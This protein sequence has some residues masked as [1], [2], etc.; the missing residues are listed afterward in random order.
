VKRPPQEL[1]NIDVSYDRTS[2]ATNDTI[3]ASVQVTN[4]DPRAANMIVVDLGLPPGFEVMSEDLQKLAAEKTI[5]KFTVA[6]RQIIV[7]LDRLAPHKPL[8]FS[9]RLRAKYPIKAATPASK[10][11][12]YYNPEISAT[13]KPID[14][15]VK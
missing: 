12:R 2:L 7:Y 1:L 13:A 9:Y 10:V 14:L 6:A 3:T 11:Y 5:Q 4:N 15:E 8:A